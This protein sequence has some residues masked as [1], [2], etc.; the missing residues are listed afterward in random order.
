MKRTVCTVLFRR[1]FVAFALEERRSERILE[2]RS[3]RKLLL[4]V[5]TRIGKRVFSKLHTS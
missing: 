3:V 1:W 5:D 4:G 2:K